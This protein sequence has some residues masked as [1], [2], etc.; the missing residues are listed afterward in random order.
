M[1]KCSLE[2]R[3]VFFADVLGFASMARGLG[4]AGAV[5]ALSDLARVLSSEDEIARWVQSDIW[6]ERHGLCD[7]LFLVADEPLAA[8][9]AAAELFFNL[10]YVHQA[11][12]S[13]VLLRG[14]IAAGEVRSTEPL[15]PE[16][17]TAN[18]VGRAVVEAVDLESSGVKGPRLLVS[19]TVARALE[20][21]HQTQGVTTFLDRTESG[22]G[23]ILWLL[24]ASKLADANGTMIGEICRAAVD[25]FLEHGRDPAIGIHYSAYLGLALRSLRRLR[26]LS[27]KQFALAVAVVGLHDKERTIRSQ[28]L[29]SS[30]SRKRLSELEALTR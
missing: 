20:A 12:D 28:L 30:D 2:E 11:S 23:E 8:C 17:G 4:A 27:S 5:D 3:I 21:G 29:Q 14:A 7:S 22:V 16:S 10:A 6:S 9:K 26:E 18:L 24:P 13:P 25:L 1:V 15:F 19:E